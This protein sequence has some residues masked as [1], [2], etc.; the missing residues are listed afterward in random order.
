MVDTEY[1]I[2][3]RYHVWQEKTS[4]GRIFMG[5]ERTTFII[6][7]NQKIAA[8][9]NRVQVEGH[10]D[11]ILKVLKGESPAPGAVTGDTVSS[12][13]ATPRAAV[14]SQT[15]ISQNK[16]GVVKNAQVA[17]KVI[18]TSKATVKL[19]QSNHSVRTASPKVQVAVKKA[20]DLKTKSKTKVETKKVM[21]K[22]TTKA[23]T[24]TTKAATKPT[25]PAVKKAVVAKKTAKPAVKKA[26]V[27]KKTAKPAAKKAVVAKP[28]AK[29]TAKPAA[30][31]AKKA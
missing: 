29:K 12:A 11:H 17:V 5:I 15:K 30:K 21:A 31:K 3:E 7:P 23:A 13:S 10:A 24:K 22:T 4:Y 27:A 6:G 9:F 28:A 19:P 20:T 18:V 26:V 2:A 25:K 8:V 14:S 16:T 1:E